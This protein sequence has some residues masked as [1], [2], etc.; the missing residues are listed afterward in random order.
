MSPQGSLTGRFETRDDLNLCRTGELI[1]RGSS[2]RIRFPD[3]DFAGKRIVGLKFTD[4]KAAWNAV[5]SKEYVTLTFVTGLHS[6]FTERVDVFIGDVHIG[7]LARGD[8]TPRILE[9][10]SKGNP[11]IEMQLKPT[12]KDFDKVY[13]SYVNF[14]IY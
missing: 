6:R 5:V 7:C 13:N 8:V 4:S 12:H 14:I 2:R 10:C 9:L 11:T 1:E 3:S